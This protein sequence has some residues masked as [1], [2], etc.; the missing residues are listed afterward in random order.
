MQVLQCH[1]SPTAPSRHCF[2]VRYW[3]RQI[4]NFTMYTAET[5][6]ALGLLRVGVKYGDYS[7]THR[8]YVVPKNGSTLLDRDSMQSTQFNWFTSGIS[9]VSSL[10]CS[11][12]QLL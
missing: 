11:L 9:S 1:V 12:Q 3:R 4:L 6:P 10:P 2:L 5:I 7:G 8:L